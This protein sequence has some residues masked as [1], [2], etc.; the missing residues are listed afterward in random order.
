MAVAKNRQNKRS[1]ALVITEALLVSYVGYITS[2]ILV[3]LDLIAEPGIENLTINIFLVTLA[4]L[5]CSLSVGLYEASLGSIGYTRSRGRAC[6]RRNR[7]ARVV[8][9]LFVS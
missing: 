2:F 7:V 4:V 5:L 1:N 3:Q 8:L 6:V 9:S